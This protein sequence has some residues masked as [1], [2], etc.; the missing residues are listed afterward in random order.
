MSFVFIFSTKAQ[1]NVIV[2][3]Q[4]VAVVGK[5]IIK[6]SDIENSYAQMRV[7]MGY[8]NAFNNRCTILESLLMQNLPN[9]K[10]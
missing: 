9:L 6:L 2:V 3:D 4:V 8:D 10:I 1:D 5:N 7:Q